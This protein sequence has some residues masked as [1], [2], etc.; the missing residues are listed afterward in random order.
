MI[1]ETLSGDF[2]L[3]ENWSENGDRKILEETVIGVI[4]AVTSITFPKFPEGK[5]PAITCGLVFA[6]NVVIVAFFKGKFKKYLGLVKPVD[7]D[8]MKM[9]W[10]KYENKPVASILNEY[11]CYLIPYSTVT[12]LAAVEV[13]R[14]QKS[15]IL[16]IFTTQQQFAFRVNAGKTRVDGDIS[17]LLGQVGISFS[18]SVRTGP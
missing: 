9:G 4:P 16:S 2:G 13:G 3:S 14:I 12:H 18:K 6:T 15:T 8:I 11:R 5:G 7:Y 10:T 17:K 1:W